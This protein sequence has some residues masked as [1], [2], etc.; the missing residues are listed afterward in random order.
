MPVR[1]NYASQNRLTCYFQHHWIAIGHSQWL[2]HLKKK[3][4]LTDPEQ[5]K[6]ST[7]YG[8]DAFVIEVRQIS[9]FSSQNDVF[10]FWLS[11]TGLQ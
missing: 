6:Y 3:T 1:M 10:F 9:S 2:I 8:N 5:V 11:V 4:Q 7:Y